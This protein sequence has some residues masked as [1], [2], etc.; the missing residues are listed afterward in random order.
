M[1]NSESNGFGIASLILGIL[2]ILLFFLG[3]FILSILAI[4]FSV[5][6]KRKSSNGMATAG[7]ILGIIGL[8]IGV[9]CVILVFFMLATYFTSI[10]PVQYE[11]SGMDYQNVRVILPG[12]FS[13]VSSSL[14]NNGINLELQNNL[15]NSVTITSIETMGQG[16]YRGVN[17]RL[18]TPREIGAG[19]REFFIIEGSPG[20]SFGN[21]NRYLGDIVVHYSQSGSIEPLTVA[22]SI[23]S[24]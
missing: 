18:E 5:V 7:L 8:A 6:Q 16:E 4:I 10:G 23:F 21:G 13:V 14:S 9:L 12:S 19:S 15:E 24:S 11:D 22:G 1:K 17:C 2:G 20:C 3:G